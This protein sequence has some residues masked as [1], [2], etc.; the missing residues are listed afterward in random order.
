MTKEVGSGRYKVERDS[1]A[2]QWDVSPLSGGSSVAGGQGS[3]MSVMPL[4]VDT[5]GANNG[6]A[7]MPP[8]THANERPSIPQRSPSRGVISG[9]GGGMF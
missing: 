1:G 7:V 3:G 9:K 6:R 5:K 4:R 2:S 8:S